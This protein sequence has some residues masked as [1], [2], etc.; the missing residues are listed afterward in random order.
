[1]NAEE[2]PAIIGPNLGCPLI[3][4]VQDLAK[5]APSPL[6][7][8]VADRWAGGT[9]PLRGL[10]E[11]KLSLRV[12]CPDDGDPGEVP[13]SVAEDP[14]EITDWNVL[15]GFTEAEGT[16]RLINNE[17]HY[18]ILGSKT[19]Y[20]IVN[21][22]PET[23]GEP[24]D[25][26]RQR[27]GRYLP[28]LYD[29]AFTREDRQTQSVNRH[30]VQFVENFHSGC[31]FIH[32]TD[33]HLAARNDVILDEVLKVRHKR[34]RT[35]IV[36]SYRNFNDQFRKVIKLA[37]ERADR[38]DLDFVIITGDIVDFAFLGWVTDTNHAENNWRTF[39]D[40][41]T[42]SGAQE[43]KK[44]NPGLKI[45]AF[46]STGNHDWRSFPYDPNLRETRGQ[47]G[48]ERQELRSYNYKMFDAEEHPDHQRITE[49]RKSI[50]KQVNRFN[51]DHFDDK[52][53]LQVAKLLADGT[54]QWA[55]PP[56]AAALGL[57]GARAAGVGTQWSGLVRSGVL[58]LLG[59]GVGVASKALVDGIMEKWVHLLAG[60][61]LHA[62]A[63]SLHY[64]LRHINPYF[65]YAFTYGHHSFIV[66]DTGP[67]A[68]TA[69]LQDGKT[70]ESIKVMTFSKSILSGSPD[71]RAFDSG[72]IHY[73]WSQIVWLEKA[74]TALNPCSDGA[75]RG[76]TFIFV[77]S[78]P[79]NFRTTPRF[80]K[81]SLWETYRTDK[82]CKWIPPQ[83]C[84]LTFGTINHFL[85]QF[86]YM[87]LGLVE[88]DLA[89]P[90]A[91][92]RFEKVDMV[93][94]GHTHRDFEFRMSVDRG[95]RVRIYSD[96][97]SEK[98]SGLG[99]AS[100]DERETWW[101]TH[102]P[103]LVQTAACGPR[104]YR[105]QNPPY[106]RIVSIDDRGSINDFRSVDSESCKEEQ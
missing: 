96:P 63:G 20:W 90:D 80:N 38:G 5:G 103:V 11:G 56:I 13:L 87:C 55:L 97:Y 17:I 77:H 42:G 106:F 37:N 15:S 7:L 57:S 99:P 49:T 89:G 66:M 16:R 43:K 104:K 94:S 41:I 73:N 60:N 54:A 76:R 33:L 35:E 8:I 19:R 69:P 36:Q 24:K 26:L 71:S 93:F 34:S 68:C 72:H 50:R 22:T 46:T 65:D 9:D 82:K 6:N 83:E 88:S 27:S 91:P 81:R 2:F 102:K 23:T 48:L 47:Y 3:V 18:H 62:D 10:F 40:I 101:E 52:L 95:R 64:Y 86:W 51:L 14:R 84:T 12:S 32:L 74:L 4:S 39:I 21:V 67:D 25:L 61:P 75:P 1:M 53:F 58:G 79:I 44:G 30:C 31:T 100:S 45:A 29:L 70:T 105:N 92:C 28:R 59:L 78:P 85:S 98:L